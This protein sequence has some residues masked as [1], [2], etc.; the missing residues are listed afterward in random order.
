MTR[1]IPLL[2][3]FACGW[4]LAALWLVL[5]GR[6][7]NQLFVWEPA[8]YKALGRPVM[9]WLWRSW[10]TPDRGSPP[11]LFIQ[12]T[13]GLELATMYSIKEVASISRVA[14]WIAL[15]RP[16]LAVNPVTKHQ[17]RRLRAC[18]LCFCSACL[19]LFCWRF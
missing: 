7:L 3:L 18:G 13:G 1:L 17:Q 5:M 4:L 15:N 11:R 16:N 19:E 12:S 2:L 8:S 10:P 14:I 9:R 6:L